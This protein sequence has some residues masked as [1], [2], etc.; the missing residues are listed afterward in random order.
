MNMYFVIHKPFGV[1]SQF[2]P[3]GDKR[4][5]K[6]LYDFPNDVYPVGRLDT[7]SEGLLIIT[8]D[9]SITHKLMHP[10]RKKEKTYW[11][12]V[13]GSITEE[14]INQLA[15]GV[16]INIKGKS[17]NTSKAR[18]KH[19]PTP[20]IEDRDPPVRYRKNIPTSWIS[21]S[22]TEG[23]NRQVRRMTA[24][25]GFPTLRLIRVGIGKL[26]TDFNEMVR[27]F[28]KKHLENLLQL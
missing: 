11:V 23:K 25:V 5:L 2:S 13:D 18:V 19:I 21:I 14:A 15:K 27:P 12:Q 8:N 10:S 20:D 1:I 9:K 28:N 7:D 16:T 24:A 26:E 3:S 17:H 4:T 6:D 22:I